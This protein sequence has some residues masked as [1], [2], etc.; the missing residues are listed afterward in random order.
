[1]MQSKALLTARGCLE[2]AIKKLSP[3]IISKMN[4]L[5]KYDSNDEPTEEQIK[6]RLYLLMAIAECLARGKDVKETLPAIFG[7]PPSTEGAEIY[8]TLQEASNCDR[9]YAEGWIEYLS[10]WELSTAETKLVRDLPGG[11]D[12]TTSEEHFSIQAYEALEL[13]EIISDL[14]KSMSSLSYVQEKRDTAL[15]KL[16]PTLE[17]A[18]LSYAANV[19]YGDMLTLFEILTGRESAYRREG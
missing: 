14:S 7:Q 11:K 16:G 13:I 15:T 10:K 4:A 18:L 9:S 6:C 2:T 17:P 12:L 8:E 1:A 19:V 3:T 5:R